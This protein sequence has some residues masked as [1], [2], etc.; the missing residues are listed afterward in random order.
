[1]VGIDRHGYTSLA[2]AS[3]DVGILKPEYLAGKDVC[4]SSQRQRLGMKAAQV[5][6]VFLEHF[7]GVPTSATA[8]GASDFSA[9]SAG[10]NIP[11]CPPRAQARLT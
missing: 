2:V 1:M 3:E 4:L 5:L 6:Y 11:A 10:R 9:F 8:F 7:L